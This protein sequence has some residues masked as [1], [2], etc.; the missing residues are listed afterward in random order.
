MAMTGVVSS[1]H[2]AS[3]L[4]VAAFVVLVSLHLAGLHAMGSIIRGRQEPGALRK[5]NYLGEI[6]FVLGVMLLLF[7]LHLATNVG[8]AAFMHMAGI[9]DSYDQR[10]FYSFENYTSLGLTRVDVDDQ[11]RMLA[12]MISFCGIFCLAWS[13]AVL[14]NLVGHLYAMTDDG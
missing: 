13:T 5:L 8:W 1:V 9:L 4:C 6:L 7:V 3:L 10:I 14:V 2:M 11:W 12:P